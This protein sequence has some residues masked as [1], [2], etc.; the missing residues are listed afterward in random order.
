MSGHDRLLLPQFFLKERTLLLFE[1]H[2][3]KRD[4]RDR[5][6]E[7]FEGEHGIRFHDEGVRS[8][9]DRAA[10]VEVVEELACSIDLALRD[11]NVARDE[12]CVRHPTNE[13]CHHL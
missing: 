4:D 5:S 8:E 12:T 6:P 1:V 13:F 3:A 7:D 11:K 2:L 10:E 9:E